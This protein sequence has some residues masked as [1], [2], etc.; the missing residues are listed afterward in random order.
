MERMSGI[1]NPFGG[2]VWYTPSTG[3]TMT[4]AENLLGIEGADGSLVAAGHQLAGQGRFSSRRWLDAPGESLL[5]TLVLP[6]SLAS[7]AAAPD[8][9]P[10][11]LV[12]AL[13]LAGWLEDL[14]I[15]PCIKWPNDLLVGGKKLAGILVTASRGRYCAGIGINVLQGDFDQDELRRPATS[16][17]LLGVGCQPLEQ[18]P[19]V[20]ARLRAAFE[21]GDW[22]SACEQRLWRLG[23]SDMVSLP[24]GTAATGRVEGLD[25]SGALLL[26]TAEGPRR[27]LSGE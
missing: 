8:A 20:L 19:A 12:L 5:F 14:G 13:G 3:S 15:Q 24:D 4:D 18:L 1:V 11:S 21:P 27:I 9:P 17:R 23:E 10:V 16:L 6:P 25:R 22:R 26:A 7:P 2:T